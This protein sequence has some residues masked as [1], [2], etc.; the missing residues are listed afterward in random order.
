VNRRGQETCQFSE[1]EE[2]EL[3]IISCSGKGILPVHHEAL[4]GRLDRA[5]DSETG[6]TEFSGWAAD[7]LHGRP[8][9]EILVFADRTLVYRTT[10]NRPRRDLLDYLGGKQFVNIGFWFTLPNKILES[11]QELRFFAVSYAETGVA[12]ELNYFFGY[13]W[14]PLRTPY[15]LEGSAKQG[16]EAIVSPRGDRIPLKKRAT[17][18]RL[19][20]VTERDDKTIFAGW[21]VDAGN[22]SLPVTL[23][24]FADKKFIDVARTDG[25]RK[26]ISDRFRTVQ[27]SKSA[28]WLEVPSSVVSEV[29]ELRIFVVSTAG[30]ASEVN[31]PFRYRW[32]SKPGQ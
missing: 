32:E 4:L 1:S 6:S 24:M 18:G 14:S 29:R 2:A 22:T 12:T 20:R 10:T 21:A 5:A 27:L 30:R 11:V 17:V 3:E 19:E 7:K 25:Y 15:W 23:V 26:D 28:F 13:K 16:T 9:D 31:Y 8:V